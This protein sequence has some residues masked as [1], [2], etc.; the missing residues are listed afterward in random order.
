MSE[1]IRPQSLELPSPGGRLD[2]RLHVAR[3]RNITVGYVTYGTSVNTHFGA[4]DSPFVA[5]VPIAGSVAVDAPGYGLQ[6]EGVGSVISPSLP[7]TVRWSR[8]SAQ[9]AIR[10][11][12]QALHAE[13]ADLV[14][15]PLSHPLRFQPC[16]SMESRGVRG[17]TSAISWLV[18]ELDRGSGLVDHPLVVA[19]VEQVIMRGLLIAQSHTYTSHLDAYTRS[20]RSSVIRAV[21]EQMDASPQT[22]F[23]VDML[24]RQ[25]GISVR[26]LQKGFRRE[27]AV[28]PLEYLRAVR[29]KRAR[30]ELLR[31]GPSEGVTVTD[32]ATRWG[33]GH[34]GWFGQRYRERYG[35]S[36]SKTLR[37]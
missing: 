5:H 7:T 21:A 9:V 20:A 33:F 18:A 16:M 37:R 17:W 28:S 24:A 2:A 32:V 4:E 29:L 6:S 23:T 1:H 26:A 34:L 19:S 10:L 31:A 35:E 25:A 8:T 13:L 30:E 12:H 22:P 3:L 36:P 14:T 27:F 11:D 15:N